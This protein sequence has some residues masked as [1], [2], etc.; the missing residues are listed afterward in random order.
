M[1]RY[2]DY[3]YSHHDNNAATSQIA[4]AA[5]WA[6]S[7]DAAPYTLPNGSRRERTQRT[8]WR[9]EEELSQ[10]VDMALAFAG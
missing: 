8:A 10:L 7:W 6:Q 4:A 3:G 9:S 5:E 2:S 1:L